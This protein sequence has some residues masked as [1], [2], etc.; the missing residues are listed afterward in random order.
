MEGA[1]TTQAAWIAVTEERLAK[2]ERGQD[3]TER[4][5]KRLKQDLSELQTLH[6]LSSSDY[7]VFSDN[8][9][10]VWYFNR[11]PDGRNVWD[12]RIGDFL[13]IY[14]CVLLAERQL[15]KCTLFDGV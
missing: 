10:V 13:M 5:T 8:S 7:L 15:A 11:A 2:L 9:K 3:R 1:E 14:R 6:L 4:D 12:Y